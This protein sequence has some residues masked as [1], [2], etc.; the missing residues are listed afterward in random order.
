MFGNASGVFAS[1]VGFQTNLMVLGPGGY[2]A[3]DYLRLGLPLT[4][5]VFAVAMTAIPLVWGFE[6]APPPVDVASPAEVAPPPA[7]VDKPGP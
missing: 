1:P 4:G 6:P 2:R 5:I 3:S 7:G